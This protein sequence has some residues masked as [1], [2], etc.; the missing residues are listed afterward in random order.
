MQN[1][2]RGDGRRCPSSHGGCRAIDPVAKAK[3]LATAGRGGRRFESS[4]V[5]QPSVVVTTA[6]SGTFLEP[7]GSTLVSAL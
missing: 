5:R 1:R 4:D 6:A 2:A 7:L 3:G